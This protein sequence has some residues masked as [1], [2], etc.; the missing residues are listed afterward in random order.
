MKFISKTLKIKEY[1]IHYI[2]SEQSPETDQTIVCVHGLPGSCNDYR[3]FADCLDSTQKVIAVDL[4]GCGKSEKPMTIDYKIRTQADYLVHFIETL[5]LNNVALI[6][7]SYGGAICQTIAAKVPDRIKH[8]VLLSSIGSIPHIIYKKLIIP[9]FLMYRLLVLPKVYSIIRPMAVYGFKRIGFPEK[10]ANNKTALTIM[11]KT[12][13]KIDFKHVG[14]DAEK[15]MCPTLYI[16]C[17]ND[18]YVQPEVRVHL[19]KKIKNFEY[20]EFEGDS[21]LLQD[22]HAEII[23]RHIEKFLGGN[24]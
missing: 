8:L 21:H 12:A 6:G 13:S 14:M 3:K 5:N 1:Q 10:T 23:S 19:Q 18:P 22:T 4:L 16:S 7:H 9:M 11:C 2:E 24:S 15:I 17:R 20:I